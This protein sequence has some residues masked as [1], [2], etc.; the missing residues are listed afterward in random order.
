MSS[1]TLS[2]SEQEHLLD[3]LHVFKVQGRDKCGRTLLLIIVKHFSG[4][5]FPRHFRSS[6]FQWRVRIS[7]T[8]TIDDDGYGASL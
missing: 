8:L 3:K 1:S 4:H 5:A 2:E 7:F 6:I